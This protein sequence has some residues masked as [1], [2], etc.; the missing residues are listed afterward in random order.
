MIEDDLSVIHGGLI[1]ATLH[2]TEKLAE[3]KQH[4][5]RKGFT[6]FYYTFDLD[7]L[8][9]SGMVYLIM[10]GKR[11]AR[12]KSFLPFLDRC[13]TVYASNVK[14]YSHI[15]AGNLKY[16][17]KKFEDRHQVHL[18]NDQLAHFTNYNPSAI[19]R[20]L[21]GK[22]DSIPSL[23][24]LLTLDLLPLERNAQNIFVNLDSYYE[25]QKRLMR[26]EIGDGERTLTSIEISD[27]SGISQEIIE[28]LSLA[29]HSI[30]KYADTY[31]RLVNLQKDYA[32]GKGR[33]K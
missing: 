10:S 16:E 22:G 5:P 15:A 1:M 23:W 31:Q 19:G 3:I 17:L 11:E 20:A 7:K 18:T 24:D 27:L 2:F 21:N 12:N 28:D 4:D 8:Y 29:C 25:L 13:L 32:Y 9:T 14:D 6:D 26:A 30:E 33:R